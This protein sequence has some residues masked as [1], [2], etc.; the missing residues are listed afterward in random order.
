MRSRIIPGLFLML[1]LALPAFAAGPGGSSLDRILPQIRRATPGTLYDAQ[2]PFP[3][4]DGQARYRLKWMTP[5]GRIIWF[6]ADART[7]RILGMAGGDVG[8]PRGRNNN[9]DDDGPPNRNQPER[10]HFRDDG[11]SPGRFDNPPGPGAIF[12]GGD[13][14]GTRDRG[15][16]RRGHRGRHGGN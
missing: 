14:D 5:D 15:D 4:P 2:G 8:R 10:R 16:G 1:A 7:G 9:D 11:D 13:D 12:N 6:D 3:G